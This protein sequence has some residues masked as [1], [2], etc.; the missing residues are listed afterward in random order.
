MVA[1]QSS[2]AQLQDS[3]EFGEPMSG[4]PA[5]LLSLCTLEMSFLMSWVGVYVAPAPFM[6][7]LRS[8]PI[9]GRGVR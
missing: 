3:W 9:L 7:A 1:L 8:R 2:P 5:T 4:T 6:Q